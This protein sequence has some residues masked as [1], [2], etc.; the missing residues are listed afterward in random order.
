MNL[1]Q[2]E[3]DTGTRCGMRVVQVLP[4]TY[5]QLVPRLVMKMQ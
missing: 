5:L 3:S 1:R 4:A 2:A